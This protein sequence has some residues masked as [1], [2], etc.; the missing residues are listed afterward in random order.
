MKKIMRSNS[1]TFDGSTRN[2]EA[3]MNK[4]DEIIDW[5]EEHEG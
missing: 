1:E 4:L 3:I 2:Q 5:I